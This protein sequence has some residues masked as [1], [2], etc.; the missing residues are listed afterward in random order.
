M[1]EKCVFRK[2]NTPQNSVCGIVTVFIVFIIQSVNCV[3]E[4]VG[5]ASTVLDMYLR[6]TQFESWLGRQLL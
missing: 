4:Q 6:G 2:I 3:T 1:L 5:L